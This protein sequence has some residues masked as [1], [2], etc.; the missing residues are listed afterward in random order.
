MVRATRRRRSWARAERPRRVTARPRRRAAS[1]GSVQIRRV[2]R[3]DHAGVGVGG[4]AREPGDLP[5]ARRDDAGPDG[6][7]RLARGAG[8]E[9]G[10]GQGGDLEVE[11]D[12]V[13]QGPGEATQIAH[14]LRRRAGAARE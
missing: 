6:G 5:G 3:P 4:G 11:I 14:A 12:A 7:R 8:G 10:V 13:E 9:L 2:W 1:G